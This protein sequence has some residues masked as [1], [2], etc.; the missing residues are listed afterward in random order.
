MQVEP[1]K[2]FKE[3]EPILKSEHD[4]LKNKNFDTYYIDSQI[5]NKNDPVSKYDINDILKSKEII[6]FTSEKK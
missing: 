3:I 1:N 5:I 6:I 2:T 4:E